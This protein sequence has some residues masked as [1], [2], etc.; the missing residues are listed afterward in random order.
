MFRES[1]LFYVFRSDIYNGLPKPELIPG[2][3][4]DIEEKG[5]LGAFHGGG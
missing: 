1:E 2:V 4:R 5:S 3:Q